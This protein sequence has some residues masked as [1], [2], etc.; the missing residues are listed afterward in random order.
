MYIQITGYPGMII[1]MRSTYAAPFYIFKNNHTFHVVGI[2]EFITKHG[3][4]VRSNLGS[5]LKM[6]TTSTILCQTSLSKNIKTVEIQ[7]PL[8]GNICDAVELT[9][10]GLEAGPASQ[11][12]QRLLPDI[13]A[14]PPLTLSAQT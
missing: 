8:I 10:W 4:K 1:G 11:Q 2:Q 7:V 14:C 12:K 5:V 6:C 3:L 9:W 13:G